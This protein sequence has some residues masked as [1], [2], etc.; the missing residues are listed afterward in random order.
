MK[1]FFLFAAL[2][3]AA[4]INAKEIVIDL[5]TGVKEVSVATDDAT[6]S[7]AGD[8]LTINWTAATP[9][10]FEYQGVAFPLD[11]LTKIT[12]ISFEYKGDGAEAY[13][14]E[15]VCIYPYLRDSEG[16]RWFKKDFWPN[17]LTTDWD[18]LSALPDNCPWDGA[19][20]AFG[21]KPFV[22]LAFAAN[23][24]KAG[25]GTFYL[26]NVKLTVD[27]GTNI[28]NI[29]AEAKTTKVIRDGQILIL[30]DGK[31]FNALGAEVK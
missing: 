17:A 28:D 31:T 19:T 13:K 5:S 14:P 11:N 16:N 25:T 24:S 30:R 2:F 22:Q 7:L 23:P 8:V 20:Y 12:N 27:D 10:Y 21:E 18:A 26:R 6:F 9:D 4:T 29:A 15:G 3:A 1:K